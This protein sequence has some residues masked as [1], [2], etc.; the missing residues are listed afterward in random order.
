MKIKQEQIQFVDK[1]LLPFF[2]IK[3]VIDY[4]SSI[5]VKII[6][7]N[8]TIINK[9]NNNIDELKKVFPVREF[10][11]H[12]SD[13]KI[14]T[15]AQ[16]FGLLKKCL[17]LCNIL[18]ELVEQN[19]VTYLRLIKENNILQ[20]Y[21][22]QYKMTDIRCNIN[23][24]VKVIENNTKTKLKNKN[25]IP[26]DDLINGIKRYT[27]EE[28]YLPLHKYL[29]KDRNKY[30][31][32]LNNSDLFIKNISCLQIEF[33]GNKEDN[34]YDYLFDNL[35]FS[36]TSF[37]NGQIFNDNV[38]KNKSIFPNII[39]PFESTKYTNYVFRLDF[40]NDIEDHRIKNYVNDITIKLVFKVPIFKKSIYKKLNDINKPPYIK[41]NNGNNTIF[42]SNGKLD[43]KNSLDLQKINT[44]VT[45][46][47]NKLLED[48][49]D[50]GKTFILNNKKYFQWDKT[51]D[52]SDYL[53]P[54]C[55]DYDCN[56]YKDVYDFNCGYYQY[57]NNKFIIKH[58]LTRLSDTISDIK[59]IIPQLKCDEDFKC[60]YKSWVF[61]E[62]KE[63]TL[64]K[65]DN[66]YE[67]KDFTIE[68]QFN[69]IYEGVY[70]ADIILEINNKNNI[71]NIFENVKLSYYNYFWNMEN[72]EK[73]SSNK[74]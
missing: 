12:K 7:E 71:N 5:S 36:L 6:K 11:L 13:N 49:I 17:L 37:N 51:P 4:E 66:Y 27:I 38:V 25:E 67:I 52:G 30:L 42:I 62:Q 55:L 56:F 41:I 57:I 53:K 31:I 19:R 2:G 50:K 14:K 60:Y 21:I 61:D 18:F 54:I 20:N 45:I 28:Y 58:R 47:E 24:S 1:I 69:L 63:L 72:R 39:L 16:A 32:F 43:L 8:K 64:E 40:N 73:L 3:S 9:L 44:K 59:I 48:F 70:G 35:T 26:Y 65:K 33:C 46:D 29:I 34:I 68:N 10:S 22:K 23:N 74:I 15:P